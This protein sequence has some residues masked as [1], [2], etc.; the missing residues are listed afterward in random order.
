MFLEERK[1]KTEAYN[2]VNK[3]LIKNNENKYLTLFQNRAMYTDE[4]NN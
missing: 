4:E 3:L 2:M 1:T